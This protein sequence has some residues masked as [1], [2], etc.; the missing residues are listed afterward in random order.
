MTFQ[1][2]VLI[3]AGI[4][5]ILTLAVIGL[6]IKA[7]DL[8]AVFPPELSQCPDYFKTTM[9]D[10]SLSCKR[11]HDGL[12]TCESINIG[13]A[14]FRGENGDYAKCMKAKE[15][16]ITWDGITNRQPPLC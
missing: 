7:G 14:N 15:C 5:L 4:M 10:G 9:K 8:N 11:V 6:L 16:G 3:I 2:I 1:K 12:G 13:G